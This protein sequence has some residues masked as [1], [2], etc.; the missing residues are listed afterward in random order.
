MA[1]VETPRRPAA[2]EDSDARPL[3]LWSTA[4]LVV[5]HTIGVG[6]FL[7]PAQLIGAMASPAGTLGLWLA[8][9]AL[10]LAGALTFG[11]LAARLPQGGGPYVY[12]REAWG[13]RV[14]F[15]YGWQSLLVMDPGVV[16][17]LALG[18]SQ[19]LVVLFPGA[20]GRER[21]LALAAVWALAAVGMTGLR[22]SSRFLNGLTAIKVAALLAI[23]AGAATVG[24]GS[25]AHFSPFFARRAGALPMREALGLGLIGAF[26]S[27]GGFWEAS[28]VAGEVRDPRRLLP[29]A[30]ALGTAAVTVLYVATT[31]AF[32]YL[33]PPEEARDPREFARRAGEALLGPAGPSLF[34]AV[35]SL[36]V[37]ASA[38]ALLVMAPR[39]YLAMSRDGLFPAPLAALGRRTRA[40][41]RATALLAALA[42]VYVVSGSFPQVVAFFMCTA[43][44]FV[45]L[46][47]AGLLVLRRR[48]D[49]A[50][51]FRV[52]G[53][54]A[55]TA[56]FLAFSLGVVAL[57][58]LARPIPALAGFGLV[59]AGLPFYRV[60]APGGPHA[61]RL[62]GETS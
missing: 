53:Y 58:A 31:L 49:A 52:P 15:L 25:L 62:E 40:P 41:R 23:V 1:E 2:A 19:Y 57:I 33:V 59:L 51:P 4:A 11:E 21:W 24:S 54:P 16:A 42:S 35:V 18:L 29:R 28:R 12:L 56:L 50:A 9:G 3:G 17:A 47:A 32:L 37:V 55:T 38:L 45:A 46:A 61:R 43:L 8:S 39:V 14:A 5:G 10:V 27:F 22:L 6:I 34:S 60:V 30:L 36:S 26:Y 44:V 20:A 13:P 48:D 7:T